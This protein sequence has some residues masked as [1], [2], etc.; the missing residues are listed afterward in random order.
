MA[1]QL[2]S[3]ILA[4]IA[5]SMIAV[6]YRSNSAHGVPPSFAA[7]GM[8]LAGLLWFGFRSFA[9]AGAPG[10][11]APVIVWIWG[12]ANGLAQGMAVYLY[13]VA[14]RH[15]PLAPVWCAGNLTFVTPAIFATIWMSERLTGLQTAGMIAALSCVVVSS[16]GHAEEP[17]ARATHRATPLDRV[18]YGALLFGMT[19]L[20]GLVGVALK[21]MML[22]DRGGMPLNPR[23][24]DTF[25]L[26]MYAVLFVWVL[27][28]SYRSTAVK[29]PTGR[30]VVNGLLAGAGS[31]VG[32]ILTARISGLPGGVGFAVIAVT[33]VLSGVL[34][35]SFVYREK[36]GVSWYATV[37]FAVA[38]VVL[39]NAAG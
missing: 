26:G 10:Y 33:S 8:G 37:A 39:F 36:R 38:S 31:V 16:L 17:G 19:F 7:V 14:L 21:H 34:I 32:M 25:M 28:E 35:T 30:I 18:L 1:G 20:T 29:A 12:A 9:G 24:N 3:A 11:D 5:F 4:G 2:F 13:R 15:G 22:L 6:A 23:F 27:V